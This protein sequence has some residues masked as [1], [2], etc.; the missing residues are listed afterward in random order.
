MKF[1]VKAMIQRDSKFDDKTMEFVKCNTYL[2]NPCGTDYG[3]ICHD[4]KTLK[5]LLNRLQNFKW[6]KDVVELHVCGYNSKEVI[7]VVREFKKYTF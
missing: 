1:Y 3:Y 6:R 7:H 4:L 5:G 2:S